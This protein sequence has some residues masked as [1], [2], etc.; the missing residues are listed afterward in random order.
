M[1]LI[2]THR[3]GGFSKFLLT[4]KLFFTL[5]NIKKLHQK[6]TGLYKQITPIFPT[7]KYPDLKTCADYN[8]ARLVKFHLAYLLGSVLM[9]ADKDI[10]KGGYLRLNQ[11]IKK[12]KAFY[13]K[14]RNLK[15]LFEE[16]NL[17]K[18]LLAEILEESLKLENLENLSSKNLE[19]T[20]NSKNN[21]ENQ[22]SQASNNT[23]N[24][25]ALNSCENAL[26]LNSKTPLNSTQNTLS[27][28]YLTQNLNLFKDTLNLAQ[29]Y[30]YKYEQIPAGAQKFI[31][32]NLSEIHTWLSSNE[33]KEKYLN[34][35]HPYPPLLN[36]KLL[37]DEN[38]KL[39]Y[40]T[41][42]AN[43]AWEMNLPLPPGYKLFLFVL[44]GTGMNATTYL[45]RHC[46]VKITTYWYPMDIQYIE[47]Y[48][49]LKDKTNFVAIPLNNNEKLIHLLTH[50]APAICILRDPI[51]QIKPY[52]N[53][54]GGINNNKIIREFNL[55]TDLN[56]LFRVNI[57]YQF[58]FADGTG[59]NL[60]AGINYFSQNDGQGH[61]YLDFLVRATK[62]IVTELNYFKMDEIKPEAAY[63]TFC[64]L[65]DKFNFQKPNK[66]DILFRKNTGSMDELADSYF[67]P[68]KMFVELKDKT[69]SFE[70]LNYQNESEKTNYIKEFTQNEYITN[71]L[72]V[73]LFCDKKD[74]QIL[75]ESSK[76][77]EV[78]MYL[79]EYFKR[80]QGFYEKT[81][82]SLITENKILTYMKEHSF[83]LS[84]Y[85]KIF[86][87]C[88]SEVRK[89]RP[90]IIASWKYYAE[91]EKICAHV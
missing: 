55:G 21:L 77:K 11:E 85:K 46:G 19:N 10:F 65:A 16:L 80:L 78:Q 61:F 5:K 20:L 88:Y 25:N 83:L 71:T 59:P 8:A 86:D 53:H 89:N 32:E 54:H 47:S 76:F 41:I 34:K 81:A 13:K 15:T 90:D 14:T 73:G 40:Q 3:G 87:N 69:I 37:N 52:F 31:L 91:F 68:R 33:F 72:K 75:K 60:E 30:I 23:S 67:F 38:Q 45:L 49:L 1:I 43:L 7:L 79:Q 2:K 35:N 48:N 70:V 63:D 28:D 24:S 22:S 42:P 4:P 64:K 18:E 56:E 29:I 74:F 9:R 50:R 82:K 66:S 58:R 26:N 27:F 12:A 6:Q 84:A 62:N 57:P 51:S 36:P 39:N 44:A 17:S